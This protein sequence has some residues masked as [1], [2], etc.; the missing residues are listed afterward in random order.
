M[1][2]PN[3]SFKFQ[4]VY[5]NTTPPTPSPLATPFTIK[6]LQNGGQVGI[7]TDSEADFVNLEYSKNGGAWTTYTLNDPIYLDQDETVAF[8]G[9]N[10]SGFCV[11]GVGD[12]RLKAFYSGSQLEAYGNIMSLLTGNFENATDFSFMDSP[13]NVFKYFFQADACLVHASG[14]ILPASSVP[15][16]GYDWM[17]FGQNQL[18]TPPQ[19]LATEFYNDS[20]NAMFYNCASLTASPEIFA[21]SSYQGYSFNQMFNNCGSLVEIKVHFTEW[22]NQGVWVSDVAANGIF[23]KPAALSEE[24]GD[25]RI[26][27][28]WTVSEF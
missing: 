21:T 23:Y 18:I 5:Y 3:K 2:I 12:Y 6:S 1:F 27:N 19:M 22:I 7:G 26:P 13:N 14:L 17:F 11:D 25:T 28:G 9:N 16:N 4:G 15:N 24:Y 20:C 8:S 10:P